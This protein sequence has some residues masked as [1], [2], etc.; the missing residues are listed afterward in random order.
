MRVREI[1]IAFCFQQM[2]E[3]IPQFSYANAQ[4]STT[5]LVLNVGY[6]TELE[7]METRTAL[8]RA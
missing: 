4:I 8:P 6:Y 2:H 5:C 7:K 3:K 1:S